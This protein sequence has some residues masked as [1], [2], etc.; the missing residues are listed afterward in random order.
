MR[1]VV[2]P[3]TAFPHAQPPVGRAN[4]RGLYQGTRLLSARG[5]RRPATGIRLGRTLGRGRALRRGLVEVRVELALAAAVALALAVVRRRRGRRGRGRRAGGAELGLAGRARGVARPAA[6]AARVLAEEGRGVE[7]R[8]RRLEVAAEAALDALHVVAPDLGGER[9]ARHG[10]AVVLR[11]HLDLGVGV[12][13]PHGGGQARREADEPCVVELVGRAGLAGRRAADLRPGARALLDVLLEDPRRLGGHAVLED[14]RAL[15]AVAPRQLR[16]AV[17]ER[18]L[19]DRGRA[20]AVAAGGDRRVGVGHLERGD[21][22]RQAAERLR[23]IAVEL[24]PDAHV[25]GRLLDLGGPE[26]ERELHVDRVVRL[27]RRALEAD[28]AAVVV[29]V[30]LDVDRAPRRIGE[31]QRL[32]HVAGGARVDALAQR[33]H[34][35]HHLERRAGLAVALGSE[36]ELRLA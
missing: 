29:R 31:L 4:S 27:E 21:A 14:L 11:L 9:A 1:E 24:R 8:L 25:V 17:G 23:R 32:G 33:G 22:E 19:G 20:V 3:G 28:R 6:A 36:V 30:G 18:D 13:D 35:R 26:V 15:D 16:L 5:R 7:R 10:G 12:A 34:E 2:L